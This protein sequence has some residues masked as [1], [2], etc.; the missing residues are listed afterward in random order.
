MPSNFEYSGLIA[1]AL[2]QAKVFHIR[3]NPM[4]V[5]LSCYCK[6]FHQSMDYTNAFDAIADY[7]HHYVT[8][9]NH[10][11]SV[12]GDQLITVQY[13]SIIE[14]F[15]KETKTIYDV[16]GFQWNEAK[17]GAFY[18]NRKAVATA[19]Y[20]QVS[21]PLYHSA[22]GKWRRYEEELQPLHD[23][24]LKRGIDPETGQLL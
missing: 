13:E 12:L 6:N 1:L 15:N 22:I 14:D 4:D 24:Y 18:K 3:R 21:Q 8:M 5:G 17:V 2:P 16:L 23:A 10:W 9:M 11:H 19:S 20:N 7:Y